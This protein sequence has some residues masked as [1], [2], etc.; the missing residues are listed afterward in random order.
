MNRVPRSEIARS[1]GPSP[2]TIDPALAHSLTIERIRRDDLVGAEV[3]DDDI[4]QIQT[5]EAVMDGCYDGDVTVRELAGLGDFGIG[6]LQGLDGELTVVDGEFWNIDVEGRAALADPTSR[7]PFAVLVD[8][9]EAD[10]FPL[11]GSL[12]RAAFEQAL[13]DRVPTR[14]ACYAVR[15]RGR[16]EPVTFRSVARQTPPYRPL[17]A[18]LET[19][20]RLFVVPT[21]LG[22]MVGFSFPTSAADVNL[23]GFH[24]HL[25]ADDR[26]TGGHVFDFVAHDVEVT[27]GNSRTVHLALPERNLADTLSLPD[28]MRS[29]HLRLVRVGSATGDE[30]A[31]DLG[32]DP[33]D[34]TEALRRLANRGMAERVDDTASPPDATTRFRA[35]LAPIRPATLPAALDDL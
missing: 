35:H 29:V 27:I 4:V 28:P 13:F 34:T 32:L 30:L 2:M 24:L 14:E 18:V 33:A 12:D 11:P 6:T 21:M 17:A 10:R 19:D 8:F 20:Q 5:I 22:T 26:S 7:V 1:V 31:V 15:V 9:D 16:F 3:A 23:P 25:L